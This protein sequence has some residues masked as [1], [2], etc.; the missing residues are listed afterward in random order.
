VVKRRGKDINVTL[1]YNA[2]YPDEAIMAH[3][4]FLALHEH[5]AEQGD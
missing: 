2:V 4:A 1:G 3:L 5:R